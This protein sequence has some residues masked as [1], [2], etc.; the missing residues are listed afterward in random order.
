MVVVFLRHGRAHGDGSSELPP[1]PTAAGGAMPQNDA[2]ARK[3]CRL[4]TPTH[5]Q[6]MQ[7]LVKQKRRCS[8]CGSQEQKIFPPTRE[9]RGLKT[10]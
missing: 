8:L 10:E 9:E 4:N 6:R 5:T 7:F 1:P 2:N 3:D